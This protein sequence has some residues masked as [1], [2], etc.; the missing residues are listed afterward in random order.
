M[1]LN[2]IEIDKK[3]NAQDKRREKGIKI[4]KKKWTDNLNAG[5]FFGHIDDVE[6]YYNTCMP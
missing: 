4:L 5:F 6:H 1:E 2:A 3:D